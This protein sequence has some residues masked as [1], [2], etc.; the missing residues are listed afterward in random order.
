MTDGDGG[1]LLD[2]VTAPT[3]LDVR[4][5]RAWQLPASQHCLLSAGRTFNLP[6]NACRIP[7]P[8]DRPWLLNGRLGALVRSF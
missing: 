3:E 7:M 1:V 6:N 2:V 5:E 4:S 8:S